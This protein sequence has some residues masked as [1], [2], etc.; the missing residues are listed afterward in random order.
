[1]SDE[2]GLERNKEKEIITI[3]ISRAAPSFRQYVTL[4]EYGN[5]I[6]YMI[7]FVYIG[8]IREDECSEY[9]VH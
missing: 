6:M 9:A 3:I 5:D 4:P 2:G 7:T 1:M 8:S